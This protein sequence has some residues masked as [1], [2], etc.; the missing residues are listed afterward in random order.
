LPWLQQKE[1]KDSQELADFNIQTVKK[2]AAQ[3]Y[4]QKK[5]TRP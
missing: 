4:Q 3:K 1:R 2:D 5:G